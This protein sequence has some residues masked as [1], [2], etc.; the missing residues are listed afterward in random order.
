[1][2]AADNRD[3]PRLRTFKGGAIS[4]DRVAGL[5]CIVRNLS[6]TGACVELSGATTVPDQFSLIIRPELIRR[7]CEVE[8]RKGKKVGVRFI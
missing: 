3:S 8:W 2:T 5:E 6:D 1:M 4:F 7:E